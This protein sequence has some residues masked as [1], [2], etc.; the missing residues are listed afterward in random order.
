VKRVLKNREAKTQENIKTAIFIRG[1][2]TSQT[3][4]DALSDLVR[5]FLDPVLYNG[6]DLASMSLII[7]TFF[8]LTQ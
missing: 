1:S 8:C 2:H 5:T 6:L 7:L 4:N 3:V